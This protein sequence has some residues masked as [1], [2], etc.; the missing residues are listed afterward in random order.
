MSTVS[1]EPTIR[2]L[3]EIG[4]ERYR[5]DEKWGEQNHPDIYEDSAS[6]RLYYESM[7]RHWKAKNDARVEAQNA[8]GTPKDRNAGWDGILLEEVFEALAEED[9]VRLRAE[10][11]QVAAVATNWIESIDRRRSP[12]LPSPTGGVRE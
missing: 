4:T 9:P 10:L 6:R 1:T 2:V 5:Q 12:V 3:N 7:A 8:K 11:I